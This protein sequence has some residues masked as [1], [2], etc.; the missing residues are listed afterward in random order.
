MTH[1]PFTAS[2][3]RPTHLFAAAGLGLAMFAVGCGDAAAQ[4]KTGNDASANSA[5]AGDGSNK[6]KNSD[7]KSAIQIDDKIVK[8][9]GDLPTA[10][11]A[12][13]SA[14]VQPDAANALD[15]LARCFVSGPGKGK[16]LILTG[17]T[18]PRGPTDYNMTLGG[19]RAGSIA[20][21]LATKGM[22]KNRLHTNSNGD[23][24]ATG[25]DEVSW[26]KDRKVEITLAD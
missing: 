8:L 1:H 17:N 22:E 9:C 24:G 5:K 4:P 6:D 3:R 26:A 16:G 12:F 11:F 25:T 14:E 15:A 2:L 13:D 20:D 18:D 10:H 19:H 21:F 23:L 7:T